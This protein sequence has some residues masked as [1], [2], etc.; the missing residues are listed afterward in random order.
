MNKS[1][2]QFIDSQYRELFRIPDGASIRVTYPPEDGRAP[3]VRSCIFMG[4]CHFRETGGTVYH[5][6]E[7]ARRMEALGAKYEPEAQLEKVELIPYTTGEERFYTYNRE[8]GN[9]CIG[10]ISGDFGNGGD[11]FHSSWCDHDSSRNTPEFQG[12]LHTVVYALR[13]RLL[14]DKSIMLEYCQSHPEAR[15]PE[16]GDYKVFGFKLETDTRQY[17]VRCFAEHDAHFIV[18]AYDKEVPMLEHERPVET[19]QPQQAGQNPTLAQQLDAAKKAADA[20]KAAQDAARNT[21][22]HKRPRGTGAR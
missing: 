20:G 8:E 19:P 9:T 16:T 11:R 17:Y 15:L 6:H 22:K 2:I 7:F 4:E 21:E 10:H 13:Q 12:E 1:T 18:Y 14:K 5:I 3:T